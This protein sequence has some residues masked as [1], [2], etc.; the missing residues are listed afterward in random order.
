VLFNLRE[1]S[2]LE[3]ITKKAGEFRVTS[4][5]PRLMA[6]THSPK[7]HQYLIAREV[8]DA[9]VVVNVPKLKTHR[10]AGISCALKNLVGINGNKE[11][12]PHHRIG[13]SAD[14]GD[15]YPGRDPVKRMLERLL[16]QR[17][18]STSR[19]AVRSIQLLERQLYRALRIKGDRIGVEGAWS[20]NETVARMTID[21][22]RIL[23]YGRIDGTLGDS[24]QRRVINVVDAVVAG[25]GDGPLANDELPLGM[26]LAGS[27]Q[28][29]VDLVGARL[30][31]YDPT[32]IPVLR[33][34]FEDY[35]WGI[36]GFGREDV[37]ELDADLDAGFGE[38]ASLAPS[39]RTR[40]PIGWADAATQRRSS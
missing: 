1:E 16:D 24:V 31:G 3:P 7:N 18:K 29:A 23:L 37:V 20:G 5:D 10:K 40:H 6:K 26:L 28:A 33:L 12:L 34:A 39:I 27:S 14:G 19:F 15:C 4:Y 38:K 32:K 11:Y 2:L 21:L 8:L 35:R 30:L 9:D 22:N 13:G 25:Q 36:T 17:N